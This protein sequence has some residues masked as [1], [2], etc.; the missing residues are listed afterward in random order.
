MRVIS[1]FKTVVGSAGTP[2]NLGVSTTNGVLAAGATSLTITSAVPFSPDML[3]FM[4]TLDTGANQ[5]KVQVT[6][7]SGTTFT[8]SPC[9]LAHTTGVA[10]RADDFHIAGFSASANV[11]NVGNAYLG[12]RNM[13]T[14]GAAG[15][16]KRFA[17]TASGA[18]DDSFEK[19]LNA[20]SGD[21]GNLTEFKV[22]VATGGDSLNFV[23]WV[24]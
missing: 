20:D 10:A 2:V 12:T 6:A 18:V 7:I 17:V 24:R 14:G 21:P 8:S 1:F 9:T 15:T 4:L 19:M 16:I 23:A 5:E 11:A 3:P 22:D 13:A